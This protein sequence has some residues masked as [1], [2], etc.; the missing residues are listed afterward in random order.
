[1][2]AITTQ[3]RVKDRL[4]AVAATLGLA[5]PQCFARSCELPAAAA[6][7]ETALV[8][9]LASCC[10]EL[11]AAV[12]IREWSS[13][14]PDVAVILFVPLVDH[15]GEL[16]LLFE[17]AAAGVGQ[18]MTGSDFERLEV[19]RNVVERETLSGCVA[20]VGRL[21]ARGF[22]LT[23]RE[24]DVARLLARGDPNARI[25]AILDISPHTVRRHTESVMLKLGVHTRAAVGAAL[26]GERG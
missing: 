5:A 26:R 2:L 14:N 13:R 17:L 7:D 9:D 24:A 10:H 1:M 23:T 25:A 16:R 19:W 4:R 12:A 18:L 21:P 15:E 8:V 20:L 11:R 3:S 6:R 22:G